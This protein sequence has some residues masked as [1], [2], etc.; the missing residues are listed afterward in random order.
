MGMKSRDDDVMV[1][2]LK[3]CQPFGQ[4]ASVMVIDER[5][6]TDDKRIGRDD[7]GTHQAIPYQVTKRFRTIFIAFVP[8]KLVEAG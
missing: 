2:V 8:R 7:S 3:G 4:Q 5:D 1:V 6:S